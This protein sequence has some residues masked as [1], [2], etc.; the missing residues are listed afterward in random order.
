MTFGV[1]EARASHIAGGD[2]TWQCVGQDSFL[3]TTNLFRDCAG[4]TMPTSLLTTFQNNCGQFTA[5][6]AL[7][8]SSEVSQLCPSQLSSSTCSGG[9]LPGMQQYVYQATVVIPTNMQGSTCGPIYIH[10]NTCCRNSAISNGPSNA[11]STFVGEMYY[12]NDDCNNSP[13]YTAQPIPY[14]C[15]NQVVNYNYGVTE[16]DGDSLVFSFACGFSGGAPP[17][18][19][20]L[21]YTAP[22]YSCTTPIPGI[23]INSQTGQ[24]TFSPA[25]TGNFVVVVKVVEYEPGTGNILSVTYR[26]IQIVV[27]NCS[28]DV[29]YLSQ[30]IHNF[31]S[32][33]GGGYVVDSNSVEVCVGDSIWF[34]IEFIDPDAGTGVGD[35][36]TLFSN[37]QNVLGPTDLIE[38][39]TNGD[40]A[41]MHVAWVAQPGANPFN[42]FIVSGVDDACPVPGLNTVQF[43]I[44]IIP[45][46]Y[47][48]PDRWICQNSQSATLTVEGGTTFTWYELINGTPVL[49]YD[50]NTGQGASWVNPITPSS[51]KIIEVT[52]PTV[53]AHPLVVVSNLSTACSPQDTVIINV[54]PDYTLTALPDTLICSIDSIQLNAQVTWNGASSGL[55]YQWNNINSLDYDTVQMPW[56]SPY[57]PTDY[58]VTVTSSAGCKK[59][60]T[61][62]IDLSPRFP[63]NMEIIPDDTVLCNL[64]PDGTNL[65]LDFGSNFPATCGEA[66]GACLG[67]QSLRKV[68]QG[69]FTNT[70]T[71]FPTPYAGFRASTRNQFLIRKSELNN[72]GI[73]GGRIDNIA[74]EVATVNTVNT[75]NNYT[76]KIGCTSSEDL[77][78]GYEDGLITVVN[79]YTHTVT[80]GWNTHS[81]DIPYEW[82]GNTN[83]VVEV[84]YENSAGTFNGN[85]QVMYS[86]TAYTSTRYYAVTNGSACNAF[87]TTQIISQRPN[88]RFGVC[89]GSN[90]AAFNFSWSASPSGSIITNPNGHVTQVSTP[91]SPTTYQLIVSDTFGGCTDTLTQ[92]VDV[93][94]QF[95]AGFYPNDPY[96][97]S[98]DLDTL[99]PLVGNGIWSGTG[100]VDDTLGVFDPGLVGVGSTDITYTI[101]GLCAN[102]STINVTVIPLP[103]ATITSDDEFCASGGPYQL[104]AATPGGTWNGLYITDPVTGTFNPNGSPGSYVQVTYTLTQPCVNTDTQ[105][106]KLIRPYRP[107]IVEPIELCAND[108]FQVEFTYDTT[109]AFGNGPVIANWQGA[110]FANP[111]DGVFYGANSGAGT[112]NIILEITS[113]AGDCGGFDTVQATVLPLPQLYF[114]QFEAPYCDNVTTTE[115]VRVNVP[116]ALANWSVNPIAPTTETLDLNGFIPA[117]V[118]EGAWDISVSYTDINGCTAYLSDTLNIWR[119]PETPTIPEQNFCAGEELSLIANA[120]NSDSVYWYSSEDL[121]N[122]DDLLGTGSPF[123]NGIAPDP[124]VDGP[125]T[126]WITESNNGCE[127]EA[128]EWTVP[129]FTAPDAYFSMSYKDSNGVEVFEDPHSNYD[130]VF[131]VYGRSP[132][133]IGFNAE[134]EEQGDTIVWNFF[135][136][137][138]TGWPGAAEC[139]YPALDASNSSSTS[140]TYTCNGLYEVWE[141]HSNKYGCI[142]TAKT[143]I[144]VDF[145]AEV[146]NIFTPNGDGINDEFRVLIYGLRDYQVTIFDRWGRKIYE[147]Y[148][149]D[150]GWPGVNMNGKKV[151]DGVY[152]YIATGTQANGEVYVEKG[153]VTLTGSGL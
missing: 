2:I 72:A 127:S 139:G 30:G 60:D 79:P 153:N 125:V 103:N 50:P 91:S 122:P 99:M 4:I 40:T 33:T 82:S 27:I 31:G 43:D 143:W 54:A 19:T 136:N 93:T 32:S 111:N 29:P 55:S 6:L 8:N 94:S 128:V 7:V 109:G 131:P 88:M 47:A 71:G 83:L 115:K 62:S 105:L 148:N 41:V 81:F 25:L 97:I 114:T 58:R 61:A 112:H 142:D 14:V 126:V 59:V 141:I 35:S 100:I 42:N 44:S 15:L 3:V 96:C 38:V 1:Q 67:N 110:G 144:Y 138:N 70:A 46:T 87:N 116:A 24:I 22:T 73:Y 51:G 37:I 89:E 23:S 80:T 86:P 118:G 45:S 137:G 78:D 151:T 119:T 28:N 53:G 92:F 20:P 133:E 135:A 90:P 85:V 56:A 39:Y 34:D 149:P 123:L 145:T 132:F 121:L 65:L 68:G 117:I 102:D 63:A 104:T 21:T 107:E 84:C 129:I 13:Q 18:F 74:F 9:T 106:I 124:D 147:W 26:D 16:A 76:I 49:I 130:Q 150:E 10:W 64:D 140:Y 120:E 146:P 11:G 66:Y 95:D 12:S 77:D 36:I 101:S 108:T 98:D 48:G 152:Y 57:L 134:N 17:M 5:S 52:P 69:T 113:T 75:F